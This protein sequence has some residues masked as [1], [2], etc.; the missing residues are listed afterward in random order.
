MVD[1]CLADYLT[2]MYNAYSVH[3]CCR[4]KNTH[5]Q[6]QQ[7]NCAGQ[8]RIEVMVDMCLAD[9]LTTMYNAYSVHA[10]CR[11]CAGQCRIGDIV[12][13]NAGLEVM[14]DMCLADYLTTMYNA[15]SVH[16][17]CRHCAGQCRIGGDGGH[18]SSRLSDNYVQ[19]L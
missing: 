19:C 13:D 10:C 14:V 3:A 8:C 6:Q 16:A 12:L 1:M 11:H 4:H 17:C 9:Y 15:Y 18:V 5:T 2:T 7:T